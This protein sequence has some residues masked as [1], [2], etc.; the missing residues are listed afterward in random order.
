M[1]TTRFEQYARVAGIAFLAIACFLVIRPFLAALLF[2]A[3][4]CLST[5][6][7]FRWA[8]DRLGGRGTLTALLFVLAMLLAIAL[9]V[10]L[11]GISLV[12]NSSQAIDFVRGLIDRGPFELPAWVTG[13]P[14]VGA[15]LDEYWHSLLGN[16]EEIVALAKRAAEPAKGLL[17]TAGS[18]AGEGLLQILAAIFMAFFFYRDG[19][20]VA[21]M[22]RDGMARLAGW[23]QG[24]AVV[25]TAQSAIRGVVYGLIGTA[26]AQAAVAL[27]GFLIAGVPGAMALAALTFVLS[28]IPMGPA[29]LWGGAA[30]WLYSKGETAWAV[31][32]VAYGTLVISSVDNFIKPILMSRAGNLSMLLVVLG[33]FGGVVAFG[34]IGI[35]VGPA[36]L[37]VAWGLLN[38]W[39]KAQQVRESV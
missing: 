9:P 27:V 3:V 31:F 19:E 1:D 24:E 20:E 26:L 15:S 12:T 37:A 4:L 8:R 25:D 22:V 16:R 34:F 13:L 7:A 23:E 18:A 32:M 35:F 39:L 6:P 10:A 30:A 17:V 2:A 28:F 11:A 21:R 36:L 14:V 5:W 29:I 38:A 33:V